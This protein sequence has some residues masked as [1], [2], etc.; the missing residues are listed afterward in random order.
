MTASTA[1]WCAWASWLTLLLAPFV[2]FLYVAYRLSETATRHEELAGR[3]FIGTMVYLAV[4]VPGAIFWRSR[5]FKAYW[6]GV[7]VE[8]RNYFVG[9]LTVWLTLEIGG[10]IALLGCLYSGTLMPNLIPALVAFMLFT[11]LWPSG[12]AMLN[13]VG[14][15]DDPGIYQEP[16]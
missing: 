13:P 12:K 15:V 1:L 5:T 2:L 10:I 11:P 3:W 9:M 16:T 8:P 14:N 4:V 7:P 6:T